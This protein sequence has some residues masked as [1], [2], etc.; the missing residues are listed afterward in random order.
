MWGNF[1]FNSTELRI[2]SSIIVSYNSLNLNSI[3]LFHEHHH[4]ISLNT[5]ICD[6]ETIKVTLLWLFLK[7]PSRE[8]GETSELTKYFRDS[9]DL[10]PNTNTKRIIATS[11][12]PGLDTTISLFRLEC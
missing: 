3:F 1:H 5:F 10:E 11:D 6:R 4:K 8:S 9:E 2:I 7:L 12:S